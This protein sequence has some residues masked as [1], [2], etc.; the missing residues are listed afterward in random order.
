MKIKRIMASP[1]TTVLL[2]ALSAVLLLTGGIGGTRAALTYFSEDYTSRVEMFDIGV[3][4]TENGDD[5]AHYISWRDYGN[6]SDGIWQEHTGVLL[7]NMLAEGEELHLGQAYPEALAAKNT[8]SIDEY[9]RMTI[10]RYWVEVAEDGT[11]KKRLDLD[12]T[13]IDIHLTNLDTDWILDETSTTRERY[14]LYYNRILPAGEP[15]VP[16]TDTITISGM[17]ANKVSQKI[18]K[19]GTHTTITTTY[20]YDGKEFRL[21]AEVDAVQTH[22]AEAAILSAWGRHVTV[23]GDRLSLD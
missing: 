14:V 4:L 20:E 13:L 12:P 9:V 5:E 1:V 21:E 23:S 7:A 16:C 3:T 8:G 17:T 2:F 19:E 22:N 15:T 10:N 18:E 11:E 6:I